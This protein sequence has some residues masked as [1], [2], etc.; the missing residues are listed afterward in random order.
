MNFLSKAGYV[1]YKSNL[2]NG[3]MDKLKKELVARPLCDTTKFK[4]AQQ[5]FNIYYETRDKI[6]VP[7]MYG[8][9]RFGKVDNET[10]SYTGCQTDINFTGNL[11]DEQKVFADRLKTSVYEKG[12]G[13]L[14]LQTGKGKTVIALSVIA[15]LKGKCI[16][17]VNKIS[18]LKQWELE[19]KNFIPNARIG[20]IQGG[21]IRVNDCDI[22]LAMLQSLSRINYDSSVFNSF[23][24]CVVDE[25]HNVA[26]KQFSKILFKICCRYSIGLSATPSRGDG[27][28][29][30]FS[31]HIG[32]NIIEKT[33]T[34]E[35]NCIVELYN[36][37][38]ED[39]VELK[40]V[41]KWTGEA[42]L[43]F[44][45][46]INELLSMDSRNE[47]IVKIIKEKAKDPLRKIL[48]LSDRR[49]HL[50]KLKMLL[51]DSHDS[52][53]FLGGM[54]IKDLNASRSKQIILATYSA[55][56]EG[57]SEK[58]LNT[59]ILTSPKKYIGHLDNSVKKESGKLEQIIGRIFRKEH[60]RE[61][62]PVIV[63]LC[64][65]FSFFKHQ[66]IGRTTFY[67][68]HFNNVV[69]KKISIDLD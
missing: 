59:L 42:S 63:D 13:I 35:R 34:P 10:D 57:V 22:V 19:I 37:N 53:L 7:K 44:S 48:V 56:G 26:T 68:K 41:N 50:V 1:I 67:K 31:W 28:E 69:F 62:Q 23:R 27:C 66:S 65:N 60:S 39:Y 12:G 30:V 29:Y 4:T 25:C 55:F 6:I 49:A 3:D 11:R 33:T 9:K 2:Q 58:D 15:E 24:T 17:V 47:L 5:Q 8:I 64:D 21:D 52:G 16:I 38:S 51:G 20:I 54:D 40:T 61:T 32:E 18:L 45:G 14:N 43:N 36:V 46:M